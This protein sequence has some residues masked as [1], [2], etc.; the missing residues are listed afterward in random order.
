MFNFVFVVRFLLPVPIAYFSFSTFTLLAFNKHANKQDFVFRALIAVRCL[1]A[2][3]RDY[4]RVRDGR[5]LVRQNKHNQTKLEL[6]PLPIDSKQ[7]KINHSAD[8][9][10]AKSNN[11]VFCVIRTKWGI[12][13][14]KR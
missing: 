2:C 11:V 3:L 6:I 13:S 10:V 9:D 4:A 8:T 7:I 12:L 1:S 14:T 5:V